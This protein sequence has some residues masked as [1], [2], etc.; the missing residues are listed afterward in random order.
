MSFYLVYMVNNPEECI[1]D[2]IADISRDSEKETPVL[3]T[4]HIEIKGAVNNPG[5]F[6]VNEGS[7]I[8]EAIALAGGFT[9]DAYTDNINLSKK[10][11]DEMVIYVFSKSEYQK[12]TTNSSDNTKENYYIDNALKNNVSI[13]TSETNPSD[14]PSNNT[15][16]NINIAGVTELMELPGIG[17]TKANNIITYRENN[18]YFKTIEDIKNVNGIG[19]ATFEQLK[20]YITV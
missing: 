1:C 8:N 18:G 12:G 19:D 9:E 14:S 6:T 17:E 20:A 2:N 16:I 10:L 15:L 5:V 7:I 13:I 4:M 11:S 3:S